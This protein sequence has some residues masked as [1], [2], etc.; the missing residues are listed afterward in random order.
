M[1]TPR[2]RIALVTSSYA[3]YVGGVEEHV[4]NVA[5]LL[6][7]DG[8]EVVVWTVARDGRFAV[9][10]VDGIEVWDLPTPLPTRS[11]GGIL[12]FLL[13]LPRAALLWL[14][15][16]RRLHPDV[17][18]VHCFGPNGTYALPLSRL[19]RRPLVLSAHGETLA[20]DAG[21]F[22]SSA[23]A[24]SSLRAALAHAAVVTGCSQVALDDLVAR[25]GLAPGAGE[26]VFNGVDLEEPAGPLPAGVRGRYIA[27]V[28]RVQPLKGF[29]LLLEAFARAR[30]PEDVSLVIGGDGPE[31][32]SLRRRAR[33][34]GIENRVVLPGMLARPQVVSL[35]S[36]AEIAAVPSRFEA[37][38]IAVLEGWR[39][40]VPVIATVHGGPPEF[41]HDGVDGILLDPSDTD[42]FAAAL[43]RVFDDPAA[44]QT[45][46]A[47]GAA[48]VQEFG[49]DKAVSMYESIFAR[50]VPLPARGGRYV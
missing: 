21:V 2:R 49:W 12:R 48:R 22:E 31:L 6:A 36:G 4:R 39:A 30:L 14:R 33:E 32:E 16:A 3:P 50:L 24:R 11:L 47:A 20:D 1:S 45:M 29:D 35:R 46:A 38:G 27:A 26:V 17:L 19:I 44:A 28:G 23:V 5:R 7:R 10:E 41:V 42:A 18:H 40:A 34:L 13:R 9:R 37:F 15:A 43:E 8:N 25:F